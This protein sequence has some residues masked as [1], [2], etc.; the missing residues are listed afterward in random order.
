MG[1]TRQELILELHWII[2]EQLSISLLPN[3]MFLGIRNAAIRVFLSS[4]NQCTPHK[5][6]DQRKWCSVEV[7][8]RGVHVSGGGRWGNCGA[9]C[10][11]MAPRPM[12]TTNM[13]NC[14]RICSTVNTLK[15]YRDRLKGGP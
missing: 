1:G 3:E 8:A 2:F 10:S 12:T 11:K 4:T 9:Q 14:G 6:I 13:D 5:H 15:E 7:D